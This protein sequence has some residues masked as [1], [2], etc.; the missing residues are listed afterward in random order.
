MKDGFYGVRGIH[1]G[2][3]IKRGGTDSRRCDRCGRGIKRSPG[4]ERIDGLMLCKD[5]GWDSV[6]IETAGRLSA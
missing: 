3:Q 4:R 1:V 6:Y 2:A 5:C